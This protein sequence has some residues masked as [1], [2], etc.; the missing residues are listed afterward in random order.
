MLLTVLVVDRGAALQHAGEIG[1]LQRR[2]RREGEDFFGEVQQIPPVPIGHGDQTFTGVSRQR[3]RLFLQR[4]SAGHEL[5]HGL[6]VQAFENQHLT[7]R[8]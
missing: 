6:S 7:T 3:Q 1:R 4:F 5:L 8:E 2:L